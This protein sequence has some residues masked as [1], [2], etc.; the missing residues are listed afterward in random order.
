M[1]PKPALACEA[2]ARMRNTWLLCKTPLGVVTVTNP[3]VAPVG[4]MAV[5]YVCETTWKV[6]AVPLKETPVVPVNP[7]PRI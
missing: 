3:L 2:V 4:T 5:R 6:A 1:A 7:C